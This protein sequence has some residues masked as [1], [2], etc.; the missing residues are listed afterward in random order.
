MNK[1][2]KERIVELTKEKN[3]MKR[4]TINYEFLVS[5]KERKIQQISNELINTQKNLKMLN[6]GS[7]KLD[8]I[9]TMGQF[10]KHGLRYNGTTNTV[11]TASK[12]MFVKADVTSDVATTSKTMFVTAAAK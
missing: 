5:E 11:A 8:Q 1:S 7:T 9:L 6:S 3:M 2:L 12:T 4:T 10:S